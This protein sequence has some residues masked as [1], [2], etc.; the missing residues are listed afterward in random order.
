[1]FPRELFLGIWDHIIC[2]LLP[3]VAPYPDQVLTQPDLINSPKP[4]SARSLQV[5]GWHRS[6]RRC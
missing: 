2:H 4:Y 5:T 1:M 3:A 6:L